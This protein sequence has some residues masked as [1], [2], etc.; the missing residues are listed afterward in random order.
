MAKTKTLRDALKSDLEAINGTGI[1]TTTVATVGTE[2]VNVDTVA[3]P[4]AFLIPDRS[5]EGTP[6]DVSDRVGKAVQL[7]TVQLYLQ[8]ETPNVDM[9][10][11]L[12]D[13]RNAVERSTANIGA[14]A[15]V[16]WAG[17]S[18]WSEVL[19]TEDLAVQRA[20]AEITV[21]VSYFYTRG[22]L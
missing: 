1:F 8:T 12:D 10:A 13:V 19:T 16:E 7:F 15:G 9:L 20:F 21:S 4:A 2:P 11:F 17:A 14:V 22:A 3:P 18:N 6:A 5:G